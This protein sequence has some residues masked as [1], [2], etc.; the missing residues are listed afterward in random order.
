[1]QQ[2]A[3]AVVKNIILYSILDPE[4]LSYLQRPHDA[5]DTFKDGYHHL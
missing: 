5:L 3:A 4:L 2:T 1:M